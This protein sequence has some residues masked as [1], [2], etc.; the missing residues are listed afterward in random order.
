[1]RILL[2]VLFEAARRLAAT[3]ALDNAAS[4][5]QRATRSTVELDAQLDRV[6]LDPSPRR[7]A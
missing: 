5:L 4:E 1:V 2:R 6:L 3:G 7:A